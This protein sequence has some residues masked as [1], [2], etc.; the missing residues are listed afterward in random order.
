[1]SKQPSTNGVPRID[2]HPFGQGGPCSKQP[3]GGASV[4]AFKHRGSRT[5]IGTAFGRNHVE[6]GCEFCG[7]CVSVC[8]TGTLTFGDAN[9]PESAVAALLRERR[10]KVNHPESGAG[11]NVHFLF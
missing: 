6:A 7:A 11:P 1:M 3:V 4:L 9:D 10:S 2:S 8:P 5:V